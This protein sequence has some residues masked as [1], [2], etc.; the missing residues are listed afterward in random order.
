MNKNSD[1]L[2]ISLLPI[3][4]LVLVIL[5]AG[6]FL[7]EGEIS[8]PKF[9]SGIEA[10]SLEGFPATILTSNQLEKQRVVIKSQ[11]ELDAFFAKIDSSGQ[12][13][14]TNDK[15]NFAKEYVL[16]ATTDLN[17]TDGYKM[18]IDKLVEEKENSKIL[19]KLL[20]SEPGDSCEVEKATNVAVDLVAVEKTDF[21]FEFERDKRTVE[22]D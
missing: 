22:C 17:E 21:Q 1:T 8:L 20:E 10:R 3:A 9:G 12:L 7:S 4:V 5:G 16:A 19:V 15:V 13:K 2:Y 14:L 18:K 11:E 6:Y